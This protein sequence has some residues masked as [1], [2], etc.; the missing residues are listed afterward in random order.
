MTKRVITFRTILPYNLYT[1]KWC[2]TIKIFSLWIYC[3]WYGI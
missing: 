1:C 3:I 2:K